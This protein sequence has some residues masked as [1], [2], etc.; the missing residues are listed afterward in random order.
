MVKRV[1]AVVPAAGRGVRMGISTPKQF[2]TLGGVPLFIH[3]LRVLN[4]AEVVTEIILVVPEADREQCLDEILPPFG[5]Q[6]VTQV[7][8]GGQRRQD[9]VRNGLDV[10]GADTDFVLVHDAVRPFLTRDMI[11]QAV[12]QDIRIRMTI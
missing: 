10:L 7:I 2:L 1:A 5:F 3:A 9:S 11:N 8:N 4:A 12:D 6:K